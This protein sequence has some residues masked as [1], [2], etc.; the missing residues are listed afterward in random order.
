MQDNKVNMSLDRNF[1]Q[2]AQKRYPVGVLHANEFARS[3]F[4]ARHCLSGS[5]SP[6]YGK[7]TA[8]KLGSGAPTGHLQGTMLQ[9]LPQLLSRKELRPQPNAPSEAAL[10]PQPP[11]PGWCTASELL[12]PRVPGCYISGQNT[13]GVDPWKLAE[14]SPHH[15]G[16]IWQLPSKS[17]SIPA[18]LGRG[19]S[20]WH[21]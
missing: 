6:C 7:T 14:S 18:S 17:P 15:G 10:F 8:Q 21:R 5:R 13:P 2:Q 11:R 16:S 4:G 9:L 20:C 19:P 1:L 3:P 12:P